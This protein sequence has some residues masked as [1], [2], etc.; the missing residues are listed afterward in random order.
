MYILIALLKASKRDISSIIRQGL[1][2]AVDN[3]SASMPVVMEAGGFASC[4]LLQCW[5]ALIRE[6]RSNPSKS[7]RRST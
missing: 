5:T 6:M 3:G 2:P 7:T 1:A 4:P